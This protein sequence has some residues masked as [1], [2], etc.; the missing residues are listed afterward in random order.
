MATKLISLAKLR[1]LRLGD[2][3]DG[4]IKTDL[5]EIISQGKEI[6]NLIR[7]RTGE[8]INKAYSKQQLE[9]FLNHYEIYT[10]KD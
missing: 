2:P 10:S 7:K 6:K 4:P 1:N 5:I 8:P 3:K 9:A